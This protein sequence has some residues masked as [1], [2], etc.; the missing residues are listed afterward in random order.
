MF[1]RGMDFKEPVEVMVQ[2]LPFL[3]TVTDSPFITSGLKC[4]CFS[5]VLFINSMSLLLIL[6]SI[7]DLHLL[8]S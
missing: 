1:S 2:P 3:V 4:I 5:V 7:N 6:A 8:E